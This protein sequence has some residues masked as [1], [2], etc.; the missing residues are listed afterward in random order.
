MVQD[1]ARFGSEELAVFFAGW[2]GRRAGELCLV[3]LALFYMCRG[4][5]DEEDFEQCTKYS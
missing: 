4:Y 2:W 3:L 1:A 5:K